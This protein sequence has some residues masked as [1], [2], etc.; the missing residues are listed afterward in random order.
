MLKLSVQDARCDERGWLLI[1]L[2]ALLCFCDG[3]AVVGGG[4]RV[5]SDLL[6]G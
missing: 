2:R 4:R 3:W 6:P 5:V 1:S